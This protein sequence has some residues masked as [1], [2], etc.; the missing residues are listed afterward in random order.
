M[1][2]GEGGRPTDSAGDRPAGAGKGERPLAA[3]RSPLAALLA[4][5]RISRRDAWR[6]RGRSA[7]IIVM[8]ALPVMFFSGAATWTAT[9]DVDSR[10]ALPWNLGAA[11]AKVL[12]PV[13]SDPVRQSADGAVWFDEDG[14]GA[15]GDSGVTGGGREPSREEVASFFAPGSRAVPVRGGWSG[16]RDSRGY[17]EAEV[18]EIDLRDPITTGM[19]RLVSGRLPRSAGEVA[20]A[21]GLDVGVGTRLTLDG[22]GA[23][24]TVVGVVE[25]QSGPRHVQI[26]AMPGTVPDGARQHGHTEWLVDTPAPVSWPQVRELNRKGVLVA[27]RAVIDD[28]P[29]PGGMEDPA[30]GD[31]QDPRTAAVAALGVAMVVLEVALLAGPAF[32]VGI[33]RRR[34]ELALLA[35]QG[36]AARHLRWIV[37]ADGLTLGSAASVLGSLLGVGIMAVIAPFFHRGPFDLPLGQVALVALLGV[38]S[39]LLA[40]LVPAV[41]AARTDSVAVLAGRAGRVRDRRGRPVAGL[42]LLLAGCAVAGG[43][44]RFADVRDP[45]PDRLGLLA[46]AV[47]GQL[48]LVL[49]APWLVRAA[50]G[51]AVRLPLPFRLAARDAA[52]N[53]GRTAPAVAAVLVATAAF[54]ALGVITS[55][56][57]ARNREQY[58]PSYV[59]GTTAV[60]SMSSDVRTWAEIK[61][62]AA[63][64]LPGVP[65]VEAG[66]L[67][68]PGGHSVDVVPTTF[69][70][71]E[72]C[73]R[74]GGTLG[75]LPV[76]GVDLLRHLL[77]RAD[78][79]AEA[80]LAEGKAV[81]FDPAA[82]RGGTLAF[83]DFYAGKEKTRTLPA[84]VVSGRTPVPVT[85]VLPVGSAAALGLEVRYDHLLAD[86]AVFRASQ[87]DTDR[88]RAA[89]EAVSSSAGARTENGFN[90]DE[91]VT[92]LVFAA[93]AGVLALGGT[94]AATGLAA[95]EA[96][97]DRATLAAVGASAG[98]QRLV[99]AGQ[100]AFIAGLGVAAGI[101]AGLVPGVA[102]AL[103][104]SAR[105]ASG[106]RIEIGP[107]GHRP[108]VSGVVDVP[109][110][111]LGLML[112]GLPLVAAL[113][114]AL[115]TRTRLVL[116]RRM[117]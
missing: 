79:A 94:F 90:H 67:A 3:G 68:E 108:D 30:P 69:E 6:A 70:C 1:S 13:L 81:V 56:E 113:V 77:R 80:A 111:A 99:V 37:L 73:V 46:G 17:R 106:W 100:A 85:G 104:A 39:S 35:A 55:S 16:Y 87:E 109:W 48:G 23:P 24:V 88:L 57:L 15:G 83:R 92:L 26:V 62:V 34:R 98:V 7:L 14:K 72:Y 114:A 8:V 84:V 63:A 33:R 112:V 2:A 21:P 64:A 53:R 89:V 110:A 42:V 29:P 12:G 75:E 117:T 31:R 86:P 58:L 50:A 107:G 43:S 115:F 82:V 9:E 61:R 74:S 41:Q 19:Y 71:A 103:A 60:F 91:T 96:R 93:I 5:L 47:L 25:P 51:L 76:G 105:A 36:A 11:D 27:S 20:A 52:R 45:S 78:P 65:L 116:T 97:P 18:R 59:H 49:L 66:R 102:D 4:A 40:A 38:V 95:A 22:V 32:A 28:P 101:A 54:T 44:A 10:E